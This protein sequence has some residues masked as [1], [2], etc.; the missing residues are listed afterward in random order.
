MGGTEV[1]PGL[2]QVPRHKYV[3][4]DQLS[5]MPW[6]RVRGVEVQHS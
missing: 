5:T 2:N 4:I 1:V 3:S 6:R